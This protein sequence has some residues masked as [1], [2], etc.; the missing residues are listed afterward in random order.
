MNNLQ[1]LKWTQK[2]L[3][4]LAE[5]E[6]TAYSA[7][8]EYEITEPKQGRFEIKKT[9]LGE[10]DKKSEYM[11]GFAS[12]KDAQDEAWAHYQRSMQPYVKPSPTWID[13]SKQLPNVDRDTQFVCA[14]D[15]AIDTFSKVAWFNANIGKFDY[16]HDDVLAWMPIP[17]FKQGE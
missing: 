15:S 1:P 8:H 14:Y 5:L 9:R 10:P 3:N 16:Q 11:T 17:E 12:V 2:N 4:P 7:L 13:A 6:L